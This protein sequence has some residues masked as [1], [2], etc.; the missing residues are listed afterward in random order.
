LSPE[1]KVR[2]W[3]LHFP[4]D[5]RDFASAHALLRQSLSLYSEINPENWRFK[6]A[7]NGKPVILRLGTGDKNPSVQ[8][9]DTGLESPLS[10]HPQ[11]FP[12]AGLYWTVKP[13]RLPTHGVPLDTWPI[14]I[15]TAV[16]SRD[17]AMATTS[18]SCMRQDFALK[19]ALPRCP[20]AV[21]KRRIPSILLH[22]SYFE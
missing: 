8:H 20:T 6:V 4:E 15:R 19:N 11:R 2:Q 3:Q 9:P 7:A 16:M 17:F 18:A 13:D 12:S 21:E 22:A 5:R 14:V 1:E 10:V